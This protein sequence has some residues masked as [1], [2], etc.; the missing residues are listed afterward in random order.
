MYFPKSYTVFS[1]LLALVF[2][3]GL[4]LFVYFQGGVEGAIHLSG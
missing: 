4:L 2:L 1:V 3:T